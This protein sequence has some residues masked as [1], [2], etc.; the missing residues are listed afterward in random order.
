MVV[1]VFPNGRDDQG[2]PGALVFHARFISARAYRKAGYNPFA[3]IAGLRGDW[4]VDDVDAVLPAGSLIADSSEPPR[5]I[6]AERALEIARA[7]ADRKRVVVPSAEPIDD[8]A[9]AVWALL[10]ARTRMRASFATFAYDNGNRFDL[11]ALPGRR[12][13]GLAQA[14]DPSCLI[15]ELDDPA[16]AT[17]SDATPPPKYDDTRPTPMRQRLIMNR[18]NRP[19]LLGRIVRAILPLVVASGVVGC[20]GGEEVTPEAV[21][22]ART[23]WDKAGIKDYDLEL[24]IASPTGH[25]RSTV[26]DGKVVKVESIQPDG[27]RLEAHPGDPRFYSINGQFANMLEELALSQSA[28]PFGQPR[29]TKVVMRFDPDAELGYPHWYRRDVFGTNRGV[30]I[31]IVKLEPIKQTP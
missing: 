9:H 10:P 22:L 28:E 11:I 14:R 8:L 2:R 4:S 25:Y 26:R 1:G 16:T 18:A 6:E 13:A 19:R 31:D 24:K 15:I 30:A 5:P 21:R 29:G 23:A 3:F 20:S 7:I 17:S 27:R 12:A